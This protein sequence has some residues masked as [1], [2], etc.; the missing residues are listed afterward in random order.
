MRVDGHR[1]IGGDKPRPVDFARMIPQPD[2]LVGENVSLQRR[3]AGRAGADGLH[4][5]VGVIYLQLVDFRIVAVT[6]AIG[7]EGVENGNQVDIAGAGIE[8]A[9]PR[10]DLPVRQI[11]RQNHIRRN[12]G[13]NR[14]CPQKGDHLFQIGVDGGDGL[15]RIQ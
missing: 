12:A 6:V 9:R 8:Y 11:D 4:V 14:M 13:L 2:D 7:I 1:K 10:P 3:A 15:V 5:T